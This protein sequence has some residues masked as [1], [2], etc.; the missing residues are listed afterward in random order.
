MLKPLGARVFVED[1]ITT[2]SIEERA[3]RAGIVAVVNENNRP[4]ATQGRVVAVGNDPLVQ[5]FCKVGDIVFFGP[6]SGKF[7]YH[8]DKQ[9]RSLELHELEAVEEAP[10]GVPPEGH[11]VA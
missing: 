10:S 2:L 7:I 1:I 8:K 5:E 4:R 3:K 9:Y 11:E 6:L